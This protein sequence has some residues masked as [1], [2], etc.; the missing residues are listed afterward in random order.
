[1]K[2]FKTILAGGAVVALGLLEQFDITSIV[3][4]K[5]DE[6]AVAVVGALMIYLRMITSTKVGKSD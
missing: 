5:F 2:G 6:L 3:P 1:M 4:D